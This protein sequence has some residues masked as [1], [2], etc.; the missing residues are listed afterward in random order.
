MIGGTAALYPRLGPTLPRT[1]THR[2]ESNNRLP[3]A[4]ILAIVTE[5]LAR[6]T[7]TADIAD[8]TADRDQP[9]RRP[10]WTAHASR[11]IPAQSARTKRP[12]AFAGGT[13]KP[14]IAVAPAF[15]FLAL[16]ADPRLGLARPLVL[17][18]GKKKNAERGRRS[19]S[20]C[21]WACLGPSIKIASTIPAFR[22]RR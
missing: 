11:P 16:P 9:R 19:R 10:G 7:Q 3:V 18:P 17:E 13:I 14:T 1:A 21:G 20:A 22:R 12:T 15:P 4:A 8:I 2:F 5:G 6:D